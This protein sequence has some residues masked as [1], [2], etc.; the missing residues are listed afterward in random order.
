ML[1]TAEVMAVTAAGA[2]AKPRLSRLRPVLAFARTTRPSLRH[3]LEKG[4]GLDPGQDGIYVRLNRGLACSLDVVLRYDD[5]IED[6]PTQ[7]AE[8]VAQLVMES[9]EIQPN[10]PAVSKGKLGF[11][12]DYKI[13]CSRTAG[14][15]EGS[16]DDLLLAEAL[17]RSG[18]P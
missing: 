12:E 7:W 15:A 4:E 17:D 10:V 9:S 11:R 13:W 2:A 16:C 5:S 14:R 6:E 18:V 3:F 8:V 1:T